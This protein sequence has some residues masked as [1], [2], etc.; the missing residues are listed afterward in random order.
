[1]KFIFSYLFILS[2]LITINANATTEDFF[3][4]INICEIISENECITIDKTNHRNILNIN[5]PRIQN[6][7][8]KSVTNAIGVNKGYGNNGE[9]GN[10]LSLEGYVNDVNIKITF[11]KVV[12]G[13]FNIGPV[14]IP[15]GNDVL[16]EVLDENKSTNLLIKNCLKMSY[17]AQSNLAVYS[18]G[19]SLKSL[20]I[21]NDSGETLDYENSI[22]DTIFELINCSL[23]RTSAN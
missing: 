6:I 4:G 17:I 9:L 2:T 13:V 22:E 15:E 14:S 20:S 16:Y 8:I 12:P 3:V 5:P 21:R 18:L 19:M 1:M 23:K 10:K 7:K 11:K